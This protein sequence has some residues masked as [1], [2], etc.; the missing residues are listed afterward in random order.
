[1]GADPSSLPDTHVLQIPPLLNHAMCSNIHALYGVLVG[2]G[3]ESYTEGSCGCRWGG[4]KV[5]RASSGELPLGQRGARG[6][7]RSVLGLAVARG[8]YS[9]QN[10]EL[11]GVNLVFEC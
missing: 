11:P 6:T 10:L 7:V 4:Q 8:D 2:R 9:G 1:M 3:G 5:R